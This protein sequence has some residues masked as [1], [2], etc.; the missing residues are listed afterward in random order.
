MQVEIAL[1]RW[2]VKAD[3]PLQQIRDAGSEGSLRPL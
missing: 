3:T 2:Q 1:A